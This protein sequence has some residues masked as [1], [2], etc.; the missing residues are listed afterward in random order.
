MPELTK[1]QTGF[2]EPQGPFKLDTG[3]AGS[4]GVYFE[5]DE[6]TG[7]YRSAEDE[8]G[9]SIDGTQK[10]NFTSEGLKF[11]GTS[12]DGTPFMGAIDKDISGT[13]VDIF[14][15]DTSKDSDGGAWRQRTSHTSWYNETLNTATRGS[16]R[17]FPAVAVLVLTS[18]S[19]TIYD[20]DDPD[21]PM[22]MVF[23]T[24][25]GNLIGGSTSLNAVTALNGIIVTAASG[26]TMETRFISDTPLDWYTNQLYQ[27]K[28]NIEQR[29]DTLGFTL[30]E[31]Y[32][33]V[34]ANCNDVAM[35]VLPSAPIDSAT[36]L[37]IPT[38]AVATD[39][40]TSIIRDDGTVI[41][42]Y[43]YAHGYVAFDDSHN[44]II[45]RDAESIL[46]GGP[47]PNADI[48]EVTWRSQSDVT[49]FGYP[50]D[51]N[52][53][54][55][56]SGGFDPGDVSALTKNAF[57]YPSRL[58]KFDLNISD[59]NGTMVAYAASSYNTGWMHGDIKGAFLSDTDDTN[60]TGS[61]L[62]TNGTF[63]TN[64]DGW[65]ATNSTITIVSNT[66]K[67]DD[68]GGN[69]AAYQAITTVVGET[70]TISFDVVEITGLTAR[71]HIST[72]EP[73]AGYTGT[74]LHE[75]TELGSHAVTFI[76]TGTTTYIQ[77]S[78][79]GTYYVRYDNISVRIAD[80][81]RS[82][83]N[84][85]LQVFGTITK[86][87]V[88]T[89][90]E[91][92]AYSG[93]STSNYLEQPPN[94]DM[95][96]GTGDF[97]VMGWAKPTNNITGY[98]WEYGQALNTS[99]YTEMFYHQPTGLFKFYLNG[100][101]DVTGAVTLNQWHHFVAMRTGG[102]MYMYI[103]G[104]LVDTA[105]NGASLSNSNAKL[106]IGIR[107][108]DIITPFYGQIALVRMGA[109]APSPEQIKKI[110]EDE[111]VLFQEN[112][113]CTLYGSSDAVTALAYDEVKNILSVGTSSGR[114]D[115]N[116][117]RRINN[118][119]TAVTTAISAYDSFIVEQ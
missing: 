56:V 31:S 49:Y 84:N 79:E 109:S 101:G 50:T 8:I 19:L 107:A 2:L 112:S 30:I 36:G 82:V 46:Y 104:I 65:T 96:V 99:G 95:N 86:S 108:Y 12:L 13:A 106:R 117:L 27:Y 32:G 85:G 60:V 116:G 61:E 64:T 67:V 94:T 10:Y 6:T 55:V 93:W 16:R 43:T 18:T 39:G 81:D 37:P 4:P 53:D 5:G 41:D 98:I 111:K 63:T 57:G 26:Y 33:I 52:I 38:I 21:L 100:Q 7:F 77:F 48:G 87:A 114:S 73:N 35:T 20:G 24:T 83:N 78:S 70:Y 17:E 34:N 80:P 47:I 15:Y 54:V 29:N 68:N 11:N 71:V 74:R 3:T 69:S 9:V 88:A 119:T 62:V 23:N 102:T 89:G 97:Y 91:L 22:W 76:A 58:V 51:A 42:V 113:A 59:A 105:S 44:L 1:V 72:L 25:S 118:T 90:A 75:S 45:G 40:G 115:F 28:G 14:I 110:Y 103:N 92:V 66:L